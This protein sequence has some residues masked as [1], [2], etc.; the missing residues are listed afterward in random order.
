[1]TFQEIFG[2]RFQPQSWINQNGFLHTWALHIRSLITKLWYLEAKVQWLSKFSMVASSSMLKKCKSV[3]VA[4]LSTLALSW[5]LPWFS[6]DVCTLMETILMSIS[7]ISLKRNGQWFLKQVQFYRVN[8]H[9]FLWMMF[10]CY[11]LEYFKN[12]RVVNGS[13]PEFDSQHIIPKFK[14]TRKMSTMPQKTSK[15]FEMGTTWHCY[16]IYFF[17]IK[18]QTKFNKI[19]FN[20]PLWGFGVLGPCCRW[21]ISIAR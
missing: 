13:F 19:N 4:V 20:S 14:K 5:T 16:L 7:T 1:M 6:T 3:S 12:T 8:E 17:S 18:Q 21:L 10:N 9:L 2:K 15:S 11:L